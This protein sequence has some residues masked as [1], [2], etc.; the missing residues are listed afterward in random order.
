MEG[1]KRI[2]L[3]LPIQELWIGQRLM[4][5]I[6]ERDL[7]T[8]EIS[9]LLSSGVAWRFVIADVGKPLE[10]IPNIET[11]DFWQREVKAHV[12]K[13]DGR[14]MFEEFPGSYFY[15]ASEWKS[16]EGETIIVPFEDAL[17]MR[18]CSLRRHP[19]GA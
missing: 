17:A 5:T 7:D 12:A 11:Y 19:T 15:Y 14:V 8:D 1:K 18:V 16:Y 6:K 3:E 2:V 10:W 9:S 4:S 13:P